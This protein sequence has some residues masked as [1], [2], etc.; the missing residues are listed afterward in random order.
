MGASPSIVSGVGLLDILIRLTIDAGSSTMCSR[1][2][3]LFDRPSLDWV[4]ERFL[5]RSSAPSL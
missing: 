5:Y 3:R 2:C 1:C 4:P